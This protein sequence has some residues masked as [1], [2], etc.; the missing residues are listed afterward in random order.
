MAVGGLVLARRAMAGDVWLS[1]GR[2]LPVSI[3]VVVGDELMVLTDG[4]GPGVEL[5]YTLTPMQYARQA[6]IFGAAGQER[7]GKMKVG[8]VGCGGIG[9]LIV[10][11]L[12]RLGVGYFVVIDPDFVSKTNLSRLPEA[13]LRDATGMFGS[14]WFGT[15]LR[16]LGL[17]APTMKVDLARRII[18]GANPAAKVEAVIGDVADDHV[19]RKLVDCDFLFLAADTML[20]RDVVNQL[21]YQYMIPTLQVG[22]KIVVQKATGTVLDVYGVVRSLG[23]MAGCLRCNDLI[24]LSKLAEEVL[25]DEQQR[26]NQRYVDEPDIAAPSVITLNS[27]T[28][29]WAA[30]DFMQYATGLGRPSSD[31]RI[32]R[33]RP[34]AP[35]QPQL[36]LQTPHANA[37]CHVCGS[38]R[39]SASARGDGVDLP[40]RI[41][42]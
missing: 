40:T 17:N 25:G 12:S 42:S 22:S 15:I 38:G 20:A 21:A 9:M 29:G 39:T 27:L 11:A 37:E 24:N 18:H 28:A 19:A 13:R 33:S 36:V 16:K 6:L 26:Q 14:G 3:T 23:T 41:A 10:Q 31:F 8:I 4:H 2:R 34:A 7:L 1:D 30:N 5:G 32:L 35:S